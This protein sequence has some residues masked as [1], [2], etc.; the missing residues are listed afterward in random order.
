MKY[1]AHNMIKGV[2]YELKKK[3]Y[4]ALKETEIYET[5]RRE[6]LIK[7]DPKMTEIIELAVHAFKQLL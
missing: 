6:N 7:M 4:Q 5:W 1:P 2:I 3:K